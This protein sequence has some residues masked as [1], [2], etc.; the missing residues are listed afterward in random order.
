MKLFFHSDR[1]KIRKYRQ[2][3]DFLGYV[4]F[5]YHQILR[6]KTKRRMFRKIEQKI[7]ELKQSKV[8]E[9]SFNQSIQ[10]YLGVLNTLQYIQT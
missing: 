1:I 3:I 7:K 10:S 2:G 4:S 8:S 5:P 9:E 6:T